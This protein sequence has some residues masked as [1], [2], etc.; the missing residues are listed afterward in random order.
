M[1]RP[2]HVGVTGP[3]APFAAGFA[4]NLAEQGYKR[5][6]ASDHLYLMAQ[7]SRWLVT[8]SLGAEDLSASGVESFRGWR[9]AAGYVSS[10]SSKRM[11]RLVD[12]LVGIGVVPRFEPALA[13]TPVELLMERYRCY[14]AEERGLSTSSIRN[15]ADVAR[16]F[17]SHLSPEEDE[18]DLE[19]L[20]T[21]EI[22]EFVLLECR[23]CKVGSAKSMTTRLR[24]LLRFLYA[25]GLT[26]NVLAGAVPSVASWRLAS[27]PTAIDASDVAR[28]LRSCDRRRA[29]GRRDFAVLMIL[30]RLGLRA[31]EVAKLQLDSIDWRA[32]EVVVQGKGSRE[33]RLPLPVD[34]GEAIVGWLERGRPQCAN[35]SLFTRVRAPWHG[36]SSGG[37]SVI[38]THACDRAGLA[39]AGAHRLRHTAATG[40]LRAGG[41]LAEVGQVLRHQRAE[42]TS[43]YAKV[44]RRSLV[45]VVR[46]WPGG[47]A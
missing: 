47:V 45:A 9:R 18:L 40:M 16:A 33:D 10:L 14:L 42:T 29:M 41:S 32:G 13:C 12:Y 27:L 2:G 20:T 30:S 5:K 17:L 23:R 39:P 38:V 1:G 15:Y 35:R 43:I 31:G 7:V 11:S 21:A 28:L 36:L 19:A 37:V 6:G 4:E 25:V 44:D 34:V 8:E 46:P 3:L 26:P 24:A 22:T